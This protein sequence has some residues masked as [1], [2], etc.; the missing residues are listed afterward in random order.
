MTPAVSFRIIDLGHTAEQHKVRL[1]LYKKLPVE[2]AVI[3]QFF[4]AKIL[5]IALIL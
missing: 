5:K 2:T 4:D 1:N 3:A